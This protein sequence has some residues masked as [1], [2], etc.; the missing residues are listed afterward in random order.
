[1]PGRTD[2]EI[3]NYWRTRVQKQAKQ[4]KCDVNSKQF[5][6]A[7]RYV[8]MPRLVERIQAASSRSG[9]SNNTNNSVANSTVVGSVTQP[10]EFGCGQV[11]ANLTAEEQSSMGASSDSLGGTKLVSDMG[12]CSL[13]GN[14]NNNHSQASQ[15]SYP[16]TLDSPYGYLNHGLDF[17]VTQQDGWFGEDM[18][19]ENA[20]SMDDNWVL[21]QQLRSGL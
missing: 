9:S 14:N 18:I 5:K 7:M 6:D 8:W 4:L 19:L 13:Q 15:I 11:N 3:K 1:M 2:N 21:E 17:S 16:E 20:W 12:Y 10:I